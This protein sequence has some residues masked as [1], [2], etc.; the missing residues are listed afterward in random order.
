ELPPGMDI[1][2]W[3]DVTEAERE[4]IRRSHAEKP[5]IA[6]D[7]IP[8]DHEENYDVATSIALRQNGKV[9][10]WVINHQ[11]TQ[12]MVRFTCSFVRMDL[13]RMGRIVWLYVDSV[14]RAGE[15]GYYEAMWTVPL[16]HP[17]TVAFTR[18]WMAPYSTFFGETRGVEKRW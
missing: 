6:P 17:R 3:K 18:R 4:E 5:W 16:K 8:F 12:K 11:M 10:G 7:L 13:Q 9:V 15:N 1:V 14:R 2:A